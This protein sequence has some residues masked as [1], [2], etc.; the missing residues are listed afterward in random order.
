[1][2]NKQRKSQRHKKRK[3]AA[4]KLNENNLNFWFDDFRRNTKNIETAVERLGTDAPNSFW[5][6]FRQVENLYHI[7]RETMNISIIDDNEEENELQISTCCTDCFY[8][9][10]NIVISSLDLSKLQKIFG[11]NNSIKVPSYVK[12]EKD[13]INYALK[14]L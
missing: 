10:F 5:E 3:A 12:N 7:K 8:T 9:K 14:N 4:N 6:Q 11:S 1:M 13:L 2:S